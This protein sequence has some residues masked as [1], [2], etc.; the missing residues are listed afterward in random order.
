MEHFEGIESIRCSLETRNG[1][2]KLL[3]PEYGKLTDL[4]KFMI[5]KEEASCENRPA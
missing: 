5:D 4:Y 1:A 2:E 3:K